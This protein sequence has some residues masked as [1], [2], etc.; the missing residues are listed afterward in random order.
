MSIQ[1]YTQEQLEEMV[2]NGSWYDRLRAAGQSYALDKLV[3]DEHYWVRREVAYRAGVLGR[4]DL[5][6]KLID[7]EH[8]IV[9]EE[10]ARQ[11]YELRRTDLL[12]K[13]ADDEDE[14]VRFWTQTIRWV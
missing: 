2:S 10:V 9:R 14:D 3:D 7:D 5:L 4:V 8:F 6:E 13:L 11:A 12:D 1:E